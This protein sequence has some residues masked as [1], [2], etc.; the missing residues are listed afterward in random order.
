MQTLATIDARLTKLAALIDHPA[1]PAHEA[2]AALAIWQALA[3]KRA[4]MARD[5]KR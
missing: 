4:R 2:D 5:M 1:T 3:T